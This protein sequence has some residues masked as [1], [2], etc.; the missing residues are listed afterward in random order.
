MLYVDN[1]DFLDYWCSN[2]LVDCGSVNIIND[3]EDYKLDQTDQLEKLNI[4]DNLDKPLDNYYGTRDTII[5]RPDK[6]IQYAKNK[7]SS[8]RAS[9]SKTKNYRINNIS[10]T[11]TDRSISNTDYTNK[12]NNKLSLLSKNCSISNKTN[13]IVLDSFTKNKLDHL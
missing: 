13:I 6:I 3:I 9:K 10:N 12:N 2:D 1:D 7:Y 5:D 4:Q 8:N 11:Y